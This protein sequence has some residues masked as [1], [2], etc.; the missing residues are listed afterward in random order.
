MIA[1]YRH[2][3]AQ[4]MGLNERLASLQ[5]RAAAA[6]GRP[7]ETERLRF[8]IADVKDQIGELERGSAY[9]LRVLETAKYLRAMEMNVEE[10]RLKLEADRIRVCKEEVLALVDSVT[11]VVASLGTIVQVGGGGAEPRIAAPTI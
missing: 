5:H 2:C 4:I 11:T 8:Q 3:I 9:D 7:D 10:K 1:C 6:L